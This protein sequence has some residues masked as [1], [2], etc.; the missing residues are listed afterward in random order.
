MS[1]PRADPKDS[2]INQMRRQSNVIDLKDRVCLS[3]DNTAYGGRP[4]KAA[5]A[6][7]MPVAVGGPPPLQEAI[8]VCL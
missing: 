6:S 5:S 1:C 8:G 2:G 4:L 7:R 3:G